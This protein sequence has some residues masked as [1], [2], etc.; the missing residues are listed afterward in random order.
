GVV[1]VVLC[2]VGT[3]WILQGTKV[4]AGSS[5]SGESM[6]AVIGAIVVV[7]GLACLAWAVRHRRS[8]TTD[9]S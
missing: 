4:M 7:A 2:G 1:G 3:V 9:S 8:L 6:W 5:M